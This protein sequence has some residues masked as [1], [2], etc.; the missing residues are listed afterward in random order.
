MEHREWINGLVIKLGLMTRKQE[1]YIQ[2][3]V[4]FQESLTLARQIGRPQMTAVVLYEY[5]TLHLNQQQVEA[6]EASF[7]EM[8]TIIPE[9]GQDLIALARYGMALVAAAR[10]YYDEAC[11]LGE[12]TATNLGPIRHS[13]AIEMRDL[14]YV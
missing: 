12:V 10:G 6:A 3:E 4:Y 2:A 11:K 14:L 7:R 13:T 5:S 8:L 1:N 9:G